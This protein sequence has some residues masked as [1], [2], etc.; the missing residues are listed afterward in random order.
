[1]KKTI[2][3]L[4]MF[5]S[6]ITILAQQPKISFY[7]NEGSKKTYN[8]ADLSNM[9]ISKGDSNFLMKIYYQKSSKVAS[10]LTTS[11]DSMNITDNITTL[12][13]FKLGSPEK[14]KLSEI[15]SIVLYPVANFKPVIICDQ[16]Y[17]SKNLDVEHYSNG[18]AIPQVWRRLEWDSLYKAQKG[19]WCYYKDNADTGKIYG[20]LYNWYAVNDPRG[21][22][23]K[24]WHVASDSEW[25]AMIECL[26]GASIAGGKL[27]EKGTAHWDSP[28]FGAT[29]ESGFTA[30][31]GGWRERAGIYSNTRLGFWAVF[32]TSTSA[33]DKNAYYY[34]MGNESNG[35]NRLNQHKGMGAS[36][37]C[38]RDK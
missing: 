25:T 10:F 3:I 13:V 36:V 21:L 28:N 32:W 15:D 6:V 22:A 37:R 30:L 2:I 24:G 7:M 20:K 29:N 26:G 14:F 9:L 1:M 23:P 34:E 38:V 31:P 33:S 8:I 19:A 18:D 4:S 16:L 27:K 12:S 17:M 5:L 35:V 11:M